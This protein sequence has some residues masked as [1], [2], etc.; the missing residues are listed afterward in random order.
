MTNVLVIGGGPA[1]ST[2]ATLPAKGG[3]SVTLLERATFRRYHIGES[4][5][6]SCRNILDYSGA[7]EKI[8]SYGSVP[9]LGVK[10]VGKAAEVPE[11]EAA[12]ATEGA[13]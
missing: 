9:R 3:A 12:P 11:S 4:S 13:G 6:V 5:T 1:G 2:A 8:D 7:L 10:R